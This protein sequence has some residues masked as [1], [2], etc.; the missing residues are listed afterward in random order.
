MAYGLD[1]YK[2]DGTIAYTSTDVT[3]NYIGFITV[4]ANTGTTQSFSA[5]AGMTLA[6]QQWL[7]NVV[8]NNQ[9][10]YTHTV[11]VSGN[12]VTVS[13]NGTVATNI[14]VLAQ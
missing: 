13:N 8:P 3:W 11:V 6:T 1:I 12:T 14:L 10:A 7:P 5:A 4:A 2:A 9:E